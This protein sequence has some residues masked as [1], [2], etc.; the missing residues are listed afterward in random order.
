MAEGLWQG[1]AT[2][3][4]KRAVVEVSISDSAQESPAI[5]AMP[6]L[7]WQ[8]LHGIVRLDGD[9]LTVAVVA[10]ARA[11]IEIQATLGGDKIVG[12]LRSSIGEAAP[13][14]A[15]LELARVGP[16]RA[17]YVEHEVEFDSS[18]AHLVGTLVC[19]PSPGPHPVVVWIHGT[20]AMGRTFSPYAGEAYRLARSGIASLIY[21]KRGVDESTGDWQSADFHQLAAD[22]LAGVDM[23][24]EHADIDANSIAVGGRS[25]GGW[26]APLVATTCKDIRAMVLVAAPGFTPAEQTIQYIEGKLENAGVPGESIARAS[27]LQRRVY[28]YLRTRDGHDALQAD[29]TAMATA[30]W[31]SDSYLPAVLRDEPDLMSILDFDP[32]PLWEQVNIP[33][34]CVWGAS[35]RVV[36][37]TR[38]QDAIAAALARGG[39]TSATFRRYEDV[40][41]TL[42]YPRAPDEPWDWPRL[43]SEFAHELAHWL[44]TH[45]APGDADS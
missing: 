44:K 22:A 12:T 34:L 38:S 26:I 41:H 37:A 45:L 20:G 32:I 17:L 18:D 1:H 27:S 10:L 5:L 39:N 2:H 30:P 14:S 43:A 40:D 28:D 8:N 11:S 36:P 21:D 33:V 29:L 7:G 16:A 23:L 15:T 25:Q 24:K 9:A 3:L 19:P 31:F 6:E 35:D 13:L 4:G 42:L